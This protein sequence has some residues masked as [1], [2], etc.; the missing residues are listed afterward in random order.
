[1]KKT[2]FAIIMVLSF[3]TVFGQ[4]TIEVADLES[5]GAVGITKKLHKN[6]NLNLDQQFRFDENSSS[7]SKY[8]TQLGGDLKLSK[9]FTVGA[10]YRFIRE[11]KSSGSFDNEQRWH[12]DFTFKQ[13]LER[14][15]LSYRLRMQTKNEMGISK[16]EGDEAINY[17][18]LRVKAGYNIPK[19]KLDPYFSTE[20][21]RKNT[22]ST[23]AQFN[24]LRFT[25]GTKY[26]LKKFGSIGGFYRLERELGATYPKTTYILGVKLK[27]NL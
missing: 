6:F 14:L 21:F 1:M 4:Q 25:L 13:K 5:W 10:A 24:N 17:I 23:T 27:Y 3:G 16:A 7:L 26:K 19:W 18:R 8:F 11:K 15:S 12:A 22:A 20:I 2:L 9:Q